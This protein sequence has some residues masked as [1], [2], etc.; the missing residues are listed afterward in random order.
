MCWS[1]STARAF[2]KEASRA[3]LTTCWT[4]GVLRAGSLPRAAL[5]AEVQSS[6]GSALGV[7]ASQVTLTAVAALPVAPAT[8]RRL[9]LEAVAAA[10]PH[11]P[12]LPNQFN[13][14]AQ[15]APP[16]AAMPFPRL[17]VTRPAHV[18]EARGS[19]TK[20]MRGVNP[21][22]DHGLLT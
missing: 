7:A 16:Y 2:C 8:G 17:Q 5:A 18:S 1:S 22:P 19:S 15:L 13:V 20:L 4:A 21:A 9:T 6:L 11:G 3:R 12:L 10:P 14:T